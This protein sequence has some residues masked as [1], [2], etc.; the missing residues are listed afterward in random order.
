MHPLPLATE[1]VIPFFMMRRLDGSSQNSIVIVGRQMVLQEHSE[2]FNF[3]HDSTP[4]YLKHLEKAINLSEPV[5][6]LVKF[7]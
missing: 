4:Y 6:P 2:D 5:I 3:N 1:W 7:R